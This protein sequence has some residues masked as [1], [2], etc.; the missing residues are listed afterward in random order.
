MPE[1][2]W[3][4]RIEI[5][6]W[7]PKTWKIEFLKEMMTPSALWRSIRYHWNIMIESKTPGNDFAYESEGDPNKAEN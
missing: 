6:R 3:E 5:A 1:G 4:D 7:N 2:N